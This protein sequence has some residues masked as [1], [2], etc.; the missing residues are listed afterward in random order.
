LLWKLYSTK[1]GQLAN[2][3]SQRQ[4]LFQLAIELNLAYE[5]DIEP[6]GISFGSDLILNFHAMSVRWLNMHCTGELK[7][8]M[9]GY[10]TGDKP[11]LLNLSEAY[12][13]LFYVQLFTTRA[14]LFIINYW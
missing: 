14:F 3:A 13:V 9:G 12:Y 6:M 5:C 1:L 11:Q 8:S 7:F 4:V 2:L 10:Q